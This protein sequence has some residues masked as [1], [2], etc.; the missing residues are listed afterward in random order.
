MYEQQD[1][2]DG[3]HYNIIPE[4]CCW[5]SCLAPCAG[6]G[7]IPLCIDHAKYLKS[8]LMKKK[9]LSEKV[10]AHISAYQCH[11]NQMLLE[12][13]SIIKNSSML[14]QELENGKLASSIQRFFKH[15][16]EL[17]VI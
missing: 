16:G 5:Q 14:L 12:N 9:D 8:K 1:F 4:F 11:S 2:K 13:T 17:F 10:F 3:Q 15:K 6:Q 7:K